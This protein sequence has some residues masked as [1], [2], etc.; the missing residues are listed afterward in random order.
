MDWRFFLRIHRI[1]RSNSVVM[2]LACVLVLFADLAK[3]VVVVVHVGPRWMR[4]RDPCRFQAHTGPVVLPDRVAVA[5][6]RELGCVLRPD[7]K[8]HQ[9]STFDFSRTLYIDD[10]AALI[11]SEFG[12]NRH[13]PECYNHHHRG[14][15]SEGIGTMHFM[16][17]PDEVLEGNYASDVGEA[18]RIIRPLLM[19]ELSD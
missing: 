19:D 18:K 15:E 9:Y 6:A 12:L 2:L 17:L 16:V 13:G 10:S 7:I 8:G 5:S 11:L 1:Y 4:V 14:H 3:D